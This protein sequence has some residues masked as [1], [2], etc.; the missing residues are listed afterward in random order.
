M[1]PF[2]KYL[3]ECEIVP[4]YTMSGTLEQNGIAKRHNLTL[5]DIVKSMMCRSNLSEYL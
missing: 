2:A 1:G 5:K 3:Q 4:Q